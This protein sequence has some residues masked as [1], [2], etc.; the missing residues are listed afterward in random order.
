MR[1]DWLAAAA[2]SLCAAVSVAGCGPDPKELEPSLKEALRDL[3]KAVVVNDKPTIQKYIK[4][5]AGMRGSPMAAKDAE[6]PEGRDRLYESNRK[7][8]RACFRDSGIKE[9]KDIETFMQAIKMSIDGKNAWVNFE[10]A[11]EGRRVAEIVTFRLTKTEKGWL[12]FEYG[13]LMKGMR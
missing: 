12:M 7:W 5:D 13:R 1:R 3:A 9:E 11:A 6:T 4:D 10:I 8:I 2:L